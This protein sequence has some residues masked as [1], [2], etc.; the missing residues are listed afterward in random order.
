M[1]TWL[2][3]L[4]SFTVIAV[5]AILSFLVLLSMLL[6]LFVLMRTRRRRLAGIRR[7]LDDGPPV[8]PPMEFTP[9]N[10]YRSLTPSNRSDSPDMRAASPNS[11]V[12]L[13]PYR[14]QNPYEGTVNPT[15][16]LVEE[17]TPPRRPPLLGQLPSAMSSSTWIAR[18]PQG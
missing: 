9:Q 2:T 4:L 12:G 18:R 14:P 6:G 10:T 7:T 16:P 15:T 11:A 3:A 8:L 13:I 17:D 5:V 1:W